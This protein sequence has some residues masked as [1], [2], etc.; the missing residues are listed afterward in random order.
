MNTFFEINRQS[1]I[2][3]KELS[4]ADLG[5]GTSHQ[6]HIGLYG[7]ILEFVTDA[8]NTSTAKLIYENNSKELLCLLDFIK[9]LDGSFRSPK[10]RLGGKEELEISG[11]R[12]N[13]ITRE[14]R[15]IAKAANPTEKWFLLWF[16]LKNEELV[17]YL[18]R[19]NSADYDEVRNIV[20]NF[21]AG[22]RIENSDVVFITLLNYLELKV[23]NYS[24]G[25]LQEM[26]IIAQTDE[27]PSKIIKPRVFDIERAKRAFAETGKKGEELIAVYLDKLKTEKQITN[28]KWVNK[29]KESGM[30]YDFEINSNDG[31]L[32]YTDVKTTSFI[33]EQP[34]IFSKSEI[35]FIN[36]SENYHVYRVFDLKEENPSLKICND[37]NRISNN[38]VKNIMDFEE[39]IE[40]NETILKS[41]SLGISPTNKWL[42]FAEKIILV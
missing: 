5:S 24:T 32:I 26:E 14:I 13:S 18:L 3:F 9:N 35:Y 27:I 34:M 2:G 20:P 41:L 16:G 31:K 29:S 17:F 21:E 10:I 1:K 4:P 8:H 7:D 33:F 22:G 39:Q 15:E 28:Y 11:N 12:V 25:F 40:R 23:E 37:L 42:N 19:K 36:Q 30:P 6:T 38:L